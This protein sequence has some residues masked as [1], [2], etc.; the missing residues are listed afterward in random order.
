[1]VKYLGELKP[2]GGI[3]RNA[4]FYFA[5]AMERITNG[6]EFLRW[7]SA[8]LLEKQHKIPFAQAFCAKNFIEKTKQN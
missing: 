8:I 5:F 4:I 2:G 7:W 6:L 3:N 1:M